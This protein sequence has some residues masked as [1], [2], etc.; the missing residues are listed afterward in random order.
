M[1]IILLT[2][3][4]FI[5][6]LIYERIWLD[7]QIRSIPLRICVTGTRGKSTVVRYLASIL[8]EGG[9]KVLA[10]TSGSQPRYLLPDGEEEDVPRR[11]LTSI[12]EQKKLLKKAADLQVDILIAE[13][14]SIIPENHYVEAQQIIK[15][16]IVALTNTRCD[17]TDLMGQTEDKIAAVLSQ[18]IPQ[19]VKL[20][21]CKEENRPIYQQTVNNAGGELIEVLPDISNSLFQSVPK[22]K[23]TEFSSNLDLVYMVGKYLNISKKNICSGILN[24]KDD[25]GKLKIWQYRNLKQNKS[26][27]FVNGFAAN[28]PRSTF[29]II[30]KL[31]EILPFTFL[32]GLLNLRSDRGDRTL[33]W[34]KILSKQE[35]KHFSR[36]FVTGSHAKI[37]KRRVEEITVLK[38]RSP[39]KITEAII[40]DVS[41]GSV[42]FG[43][44]NM[45]G[46]GLELVKYWHK[47]GAEYG[48]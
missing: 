13:I 11:G 30:A 3:S 8:S 27:Y 42:I 31:K 20:F 35:K 29:E 41:D 6:Y 5:L 15:P 34:I 45:G 26:V 28:D 40:A 19:K 43:F 7:R 16:D 37:V 12:I 4:L 47:T 21:V 24:V 17:H 1:L 39:E 2:V 23:K 14:M 9:K 33:Q 38:N 36:I 25:I 32:I 46:T 48:L 10:K 44:G 22:F 18:D